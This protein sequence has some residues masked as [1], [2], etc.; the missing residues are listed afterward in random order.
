M[1]RARPFLN[2]DSVPVLFGSDVCAMVLGIPINTIQKMAKKGK[3]PAHKLG[4]NYRY[5][6]N[7]IRDW[8]SAH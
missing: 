8:I 4:K 5:D 6:K 1:P 3:I 2:W 7:E